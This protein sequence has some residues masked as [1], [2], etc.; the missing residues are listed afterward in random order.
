MIQ[1]KTY[2][3]PVDKSGV[4]WVNTFHLYKGFSRKVSTIGDFIKVSVRVVKPNNWIQKKTKTKGIIVQTK[5]EIKKNDGSFIKFKTN[6]LVLLK[7]RL[8]PKGKEIVGPTTTNLRRKK[9]LT[10]FAGVI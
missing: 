2:L 3:I 6:S 5:K 7:K 4:W 1:K 8:T 10:S 9:F